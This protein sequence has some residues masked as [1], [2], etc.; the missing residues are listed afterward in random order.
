MGVQRSVIGWGTWRGFWR[1]KVLLLVPASIQ[2]IYNI[3]NQHIH[4]HICTYILY[5]ISIIYKYTEHQDMHLTHVVFSICVSFRKKYF[6]WKRLW[7]SR[8]HPI[9]HWEGNAKHMAEVEKNAR[10][11]WLSEGQQKPLPSYI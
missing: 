8:C 4:T 6:S 2:Y 3:H 11:W 10:K 9:S 1:G 5:N 7:V